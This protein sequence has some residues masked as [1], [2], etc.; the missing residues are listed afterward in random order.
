[1]R[2]RSAGVIDALG[3]VLGEWRYRACALA[4]FALALALY[5]FTLPAVYTGG[6]IG[7]VS[8]RYL[9][10]K[11]LLFAIAL[12]ALLSLALTLNVYAFR[13]SL[14]RRGGGLGLGAA[15]SSLLPAGL[16]CTPV[17]P[18]LLALLGATTPQIFGLTG[19]VQGFFATYE[20][21]ILG[22]AIVLLLFSIRLAAR[23]IMG[24]CPPARADDRAVG[25]RPG[26]ASS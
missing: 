6:I 23:P 3:L 24:A 26:E 12:S 4:I 11:L 14:R 1:M 5:A 19:R 2:F 10:A 7:L 21:A 15:L 18:T 17:V 25:A 8:L 9:D 20:P 22:F 13:A 16:C